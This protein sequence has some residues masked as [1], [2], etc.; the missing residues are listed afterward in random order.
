[1]PVS[2]FNLA[3]SLAAPASNFAMASE[4]TSTGVPNGIVTEALMNSFS[5]DGKNRKLVHPLRVM[6]VV[7]IRL[8]RP[9][10]AVT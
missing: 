8:D 10:A 2:S 6:P 4:V 7:S 1:M 5:I 3:R 9:T